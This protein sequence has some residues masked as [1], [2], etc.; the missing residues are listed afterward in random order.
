[1]AQLRAL[2]GVRGWMPPACLCGAALLLLYWVPVRWRIEHGI[3]DF[4]NLY[5]GARL[6]GTAGQYDPARYREVQAAA[7]GYSGEAWLFTRLP[8]FALPLRLLG[9]L[10]YQAAYEIWQMLCVAA[11]T[12][13]LLLWPTRDK[14]LLFLICCWSIPLSAAFASGQD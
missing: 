5:S 2:A 11:L 8:S 6:I 14:A 7:T 12:G 3:N 9:R 13:F 1:M 4:M 10:P